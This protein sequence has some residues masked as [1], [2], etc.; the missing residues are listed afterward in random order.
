MANGLSATL[1]RPMRVFRNLKTA[2]KL[3]AGF[4]LVCLL[5]V[6]V[7]VFGLSQ[8][9]ATQD[10]MNSMYVDTLV[11]I[12]EL[13]SVQ[14]A[15]ERSGALVLALALEYQ[16]DKPS[17]LQEIQATDA[18][19]DDNWA[20]YIATD[21]TG[22]EEARDGF[23]AA[24]DEWR[25]VRDSQLLQLG[26]TSL[27]GFRAVN[28]DLAQPQLLEALGHLDE[29]RGIE[30]TAATTFVDESQAAYESTRMLTIGV[31]VA[32]VALGLALALGLGRLVA[33]PLRRAVEVLDGLAAG[34]LDQ[35]LDVDT[36]DE[37]GAMATSLNTA[38][39][40]LADAMRRIGDNAATLSAASEELSA[41]SGQMSS[42]SEESSTQAGV[43]S[44]AAEQVSTNVQ[45]VAAGTEEMGASIRE[46]ASNAAEASEVAAKAV[47]AA[48]TTT[49]TVAKLGESSEEIGN[50]VKVITSIAEQ[51]NL[52]ALNATIEAARAGE[53]GKGFAVVANEVKELAQETAKATEDIARRVLAIQGDTTAAVEAIEAISTIVAQ[54]SDRQTT[55]ASAV[56]EQTATTNEMARNVAEA[57]TGAAEIARNVGGVA[58]AAAETTSGAGNTASA[59][60]EL[61]RM[62]GEL[63]DLVGR[64]RY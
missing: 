53:A 13:A 34:R 62:A 32:A 38:I 48:E 10:R 11:P 39:G 18:E 27:D 24:L 37:V 57:A 2:Q 51:T 46:I 50:V 7:G 22:R 36:R 26:Q 25:S 42:S 29:L 9:G 45:T 41:T 43:V 20:T 28:G 64:F 59:A 35:R 1:G 16:Q 47:T 12:D 5:V 52:L 30:A 56:E 17:V 61:S 31:I 21:M 49:K 19:L 4:L 23:I 14:A 6:G 54:I 15:T 8:L 40:T 33:R 58:Q 3:L 44:A 63:Q 60:G 55:I